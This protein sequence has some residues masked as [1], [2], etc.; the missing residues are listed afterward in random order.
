P[1]VIRRPSSAL[2]HS[3]SFIVHPSSRFT[4]ACPTETPITHGQN[5]AAA[6][7]AER[8]AH[9][10]FAILFVD[11]SHQRGDANRGYSPGHWQHIARSPAQGRSTQQRR[12]L[13]EA[14]VG[15][16]HRQHEGSDGAGRDRA[17]GGGWPLEAW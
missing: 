11:I 12:H 7:P 2:V 3:S 10:A 5:H 14:G 8:F 13:R 15:E 1:I 6:H 9:A 16:S 4:H 17:G